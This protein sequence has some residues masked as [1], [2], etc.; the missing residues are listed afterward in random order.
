MVVNL[1]ALAAE[2]IMKWNVRD[3]SGLH[4]GRAEL[5]AVHELGP[6]AIQ[7]P[8]VMLTNRGVWIYRGHNERDE[9][10]P[11]GNLTQAM[12]L[13]LHLE[14]EYQYFKWRISGSHWHGNYITISCSVPMPDMAAG[15]EKF[16]DVLAFAQ[17]EDLAEQITRAAL[18][19]VG[20]DVEV[21]HCMRP[22]ASPSGASG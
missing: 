15:V 1:D 3:Y 2:K 14:G 7:H 21:Q 10:E 16:R 8:H 12:G 20:E 18:Y 6:D 13:L 11:T 22:A 5:S 9:W 17:E 19:A 4:P